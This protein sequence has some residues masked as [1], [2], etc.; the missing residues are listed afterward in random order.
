MYIKLDFSYTLDLNKGTHS[1]LMIHRQNALSSHA[2]HRCA[3]GSK[4][5]YL[6]NAKPVAQVFSA[7]FKALSN[8]S[9]IGKTGERSDRHSPLFPKLTLPSGFQATSSRTA[10]RSA[11]FLFHSLSL[12]SR[13]LS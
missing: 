6:A 9:W 1:S 3:A 11:L 10:A 8:I 12:D 2:L 7:I 13:R 4:A 5:S